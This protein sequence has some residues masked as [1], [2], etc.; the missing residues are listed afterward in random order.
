MSRLRVAFLGGNG[1]CAARLAAAREAAFALGVSIDDVPYPGFEGRVRAAS[2]SAFL[3]HVA[4]GLGTPDLAYATG[5]GGLVALLLRAQGRLTAPLVLQAPVL[6]G[7]ERR[8]MPGLLRVPAVGR[9][10]RRLFQLGPFRSWFVAAHFERPLAPEVRCAFF[11]GYAACASFADLFVWLG[12]PVLRELEAQF[13]ERPQALAGVAVWWGGRDR[14]VGADEL[15]VTERALGRRLP[16][17]V[18]P[19]WG[20]YPMLDAPEDWAA[21]VARALQP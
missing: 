4:R 16:L 12:P 20:H 15:R 5:I 9:L 17:H 14:V 11:D 8:R 2:L 21:A 19:A 18:F 7:L 10:A 13:A 6:W 1:H 3:D